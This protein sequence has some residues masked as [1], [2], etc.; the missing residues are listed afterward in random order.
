MAA[1][2]HVFTA[3]QRYLVLRAHAMVAR[4][5]VRV[6]KATRRIRLTRLDLSS[7][8]RGTFIFE[9]PAV[10]LG[11]SLGRKVRA[12]RVHISAAVRRRQTRMRNCIKEFFLH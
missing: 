1:S 4:V 3:D 11:Q 6:L 12:G 9:Q 2:L 5:P 7:G 8:V 10:S